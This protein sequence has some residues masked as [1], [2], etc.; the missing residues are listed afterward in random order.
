MPRWIADAFQRLISA[1]SDASR[2][3]CAAEPAARADAPREVGD[4]SER[5]MY[6]RH[7]SQ[8]RKSVHWIQGE[9]AMAAIPAAH[10]KRSL[11]IRVDQPHKISEDDAM[12]VTEPRAR[13]DQR[14]QSWIADVNRYPRRYQLGLAGHQR[15]RRVDA[16]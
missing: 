3:T 4:D 11:I 2:L 8:L 5:R 16:R 7:D 15:N 1:C 9:C 10:H 12:L 13:Q 6:D 14:G